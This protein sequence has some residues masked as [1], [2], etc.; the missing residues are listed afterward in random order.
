MADLAGSDRVRREERGVERILIWAYGKRVIY[1]P[2]ENGIFFPACYKVF[3]TLCYYYFK[4]SEFRSPT[5]SQRILLYT[6]PVTRKPDFRRQFR[7]ASYKPIPMCLYNDGDHV[8]WTEKLSPNI[9]TSFHFSDLYR[10]RCWDLS[11]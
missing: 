11:R 9:F 7:G 10:N 8:L 1:G 5:L 3:Q 2:D 6:C 4:P